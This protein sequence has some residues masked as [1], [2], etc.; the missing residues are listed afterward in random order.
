ML[1]PLSRNNPDSGEAP[2]KTGVQ[3][4]LEAIAAAPKAAHAE[5]VVIDRRNAPFSTWTCAE[6]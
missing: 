2:V 6:R 5:R 4:Q 3:E 1:A